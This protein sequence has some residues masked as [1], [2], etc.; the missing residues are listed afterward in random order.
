MK[1]ESNKTEKHL[2]ERLRL[3]NR[4]QETQGRQNKL[5]TQGLKYNLR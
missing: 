2:P 4:M 1:A 3:D 5:E